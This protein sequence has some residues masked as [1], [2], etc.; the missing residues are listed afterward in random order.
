MVIRNVRIYT[1]PFYFGCRDFV[2]SSTAKRN[3]TFTAHTYIHMYATLL[4]NELMNKTK[5]N[6]KQTLHATSE[7]V[8]LNIMVCFYVVQ[9]NNIF[10]QNQP[11]A[12]I[13]MDT[14]IDYINN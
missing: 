12:H 10:K 7:Q 2:N 6:I 13:Y 9:N 5:K 14:W 3:A 4:N 8:I 11:V 1:P